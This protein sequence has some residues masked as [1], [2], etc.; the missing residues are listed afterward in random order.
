MRV[1]E[2]PDMLRKYGVEPV[3][4]AGWKTRGNEF[5]SRPDGALRH[6][7]AGSTSGRTPSLG[8][9]TNGRSDLPG[10]LAQILQSRESAGTKDKAYV[11]AS[12][13]ANHAGAGVWNGI[14]GNYALLGNEIEWSGPGEAFSAARIDISERIMAALLDCCTGTNNN[15]V[16]EHR[17]YATPAG[18][19]IDTNLD[20]NVMR[21][22]MAVLRSGTPSPSPTP[23]DDDM[24]NILL[25]GSD[26][27]PWWFSDG[28]SRRYCYSK[29]EAG[30]HA[31]AGLLRWNNG[32]P[33]V[34]PQAMVDQMPIIPEDWVGL[35]ENEA[36]HHKT[37]VWI[38]DSQTPK[39]AGAVKA[40]LTIPTATEIADEVIAKLPPSQSGGL[41]AAQVQAACE[42]A[43]EAQLGFLK[44]GN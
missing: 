28:L 31:Y 22:R 42:A 11:I 27:G 13:K 40:T 37:R 35:K 12:G 34:V 43:V 8:I 25:Q 21:R 23:G 26:G 1:L 30:Q 4:V 29:E 2:L 3:E 15:D 44:P 39:I 38:R 19:K 5:P 33:F 14:S 32:G 9:V 10:P 6:W 17:E 36:A 20:G 16:A 24:Q 18:R 41:T 7:T